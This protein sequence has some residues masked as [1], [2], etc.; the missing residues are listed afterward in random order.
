MFGWVGIR[1]TSWFLKGWT[2]MDVLE[3]DDA[4][5]RY[6]LNHRIF[7]NLIRLM[8]KVSQGETSNEKN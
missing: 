3:N 6:P 4:V 5:F 7:G 8:G 1:K 2:S